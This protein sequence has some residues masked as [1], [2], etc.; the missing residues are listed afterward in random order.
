MF[1]E[2]RAALRSGDIATAEA[3]ARALI[4]SDAANAEAQHLLGLALRQRGDLAAAAGAFDAAIALSPESAGYHV[5]RALLALQQRDAPA[6]QAALQEA[7][8]QDPNEIRAYIALAELALQSGELDQAEQHLRYAERINAEHPHLLAQRGQLELARGQAQQAIATLSRAAAAAPQDAL[9]QGSL[10]LALMTQ[11]HYGFAEQALRN[12]LELQPQARS[13]R[14]ALVQ[15]LLAQER[16]DEADA[17]LQQLLRDRSDDPQALTLKGQ[18]ALA[19]G[20]HDEALAALSESLRLAPEQ[21]RAL[22][23]LLS[24]WTA[25]RIPAAQARAGLEELLTRA[26]RFDLAWGAL[27]DLLR[28]DADASLDVLTRWRAA[29]PESPA[30]AEV[31]AQV[32]DARGDRVAAAELAQIAVARDPSRVPA[33]LI[34]VREELRSAQPQ[35]ARERIETMLPMVGDPDARRA[36]SA[37][38]GRACDAAGD[39]PAAVVAWREAH[40]YA[41]TPRYPALG[42]ADALR[43]AALDMHSGKGRVVDAAA[44]PI[45]LWGAP[46]SGVERVAAML[47]AAHGAVVMDDRFGAAPRDDDFRPAAAPVAEADRFGFGQRWRD[48]IAARGLDASAIDWLP[49]WDAR[50]VP[51]LRRDLAGARLIVALRDPRDMLLNW[52]AFGAPQRLGVTDAMVAAQWLSHALE[53]FVDLPDDA[54]SALRVVRLDPLGDAQRN[55]D[56]LATFLDRAGPASLDALQALERAGELPMAFPDGAWQ[57]YDV[58]LRAPFA[59]LEPLAARLAR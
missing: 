8:R 35:R 40:A 22:G 39:A 52:L 31:A 18:L 59:L 37:W 2:I 48:G 46:G 1:E 47:R 42:D 12:A 14:F 16:G 57:R 33:Q 20:A 5:S 25:L 11:R 6:A 26:P 28:G 27:L 21:P 45:L 53:Q 44:A 36:L 50:W 24:A 9:V 58:A 17:Q 54:A 49:H 51:A 43:A 3:S 19:R 10:G 4:A 38:R 29:I 7:V 15:S 13:L 41:G 34:L 30:A 32:A 55:A 56:A 23:A